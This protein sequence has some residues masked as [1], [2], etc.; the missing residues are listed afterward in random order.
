M[1][2]ASQISPAREADHVEISNRVTKLLASLGR[3]FSVTAPTGIAAINVGGERDL[4]LHLR[5]VRDIDVAFLRQG[6]RFI[7]GLELA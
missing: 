6:I 4:I 5:F 7:R 2:F 3:R 1:S